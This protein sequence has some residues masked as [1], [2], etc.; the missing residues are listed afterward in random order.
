MDEYETARRKALEENERKLRELGL[1]LAPLKSERQRKE[2]ENQHRSLDQML[3]LR[4]S[5]R[6]KAEAPE[7]VS[8]S[9]HLR[10]LTAV[11]IYSPLSVLSV[12][13]VRVS[14]KPRW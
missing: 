10:M 4:A 2:K 5:K 13:V 11:F 1:S 8:R 9:I 12:C 6:L 3:P 7:I 14:P